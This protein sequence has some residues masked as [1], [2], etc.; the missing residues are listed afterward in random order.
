[1]MTLALEH[2][3]STSCREILPVEKYFGGSA[4][5]SQGNTNQVKRN[6]LRKVYRVLNETNKPSL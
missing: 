1:M 3:F 2:H 5:Q 4:H 6:N